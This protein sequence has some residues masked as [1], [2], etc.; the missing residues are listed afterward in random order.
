MLRDEDVFLGFKLAKALCKARLSRGVSYSV[1][2]RHIAPWR[3]RVPMRRTGPITFRLA[4][5]ARDVL[6][7]SFAWRERL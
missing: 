6:L 5:R 1:F 4:S 2:D 7:C 3:N